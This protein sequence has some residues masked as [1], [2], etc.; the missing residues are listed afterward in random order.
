MTERT[1][2]S[3]LKSFARIA[4]L[5]D[6][7]IQ[8]R[9][10]SDHLRAIHAYI[11]QDSPQHS[12]GEYREEGAGPLYV[13]QRALETE[14]RRYLVH[15]RTD[16]IGAAVAGALKEFGDPKALRGADPQELA[17]KLTK[18]YGDLDHAHPFK[19]GNSRTLRTFTAQV[20]KE[21]GYHLDWDTTNADGKSRDKLYIARDLAVTERAFPGLNREKA[22][23][24]QDRAE[25]EAWAMFASRHQG[26]A[27]LDE[28][29]RQS[30]RPERA[31]AFET[32]SRD[33]AQAAHPELSGT[34]KRLDAIER[35]AKAEGLAGAD[36]AAVGRRAREVAGKA[37]SSGQVPADPA[38]AQEATK[39]TPEAKKAGPER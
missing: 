29:I 3:E 12:P 15:Y 8:G 28:L 11:F 17:G 38:P 9:F 31:Q 35:R 23:T 37:L 26:A 13:K 10:D 32:L 20:A 2:E 5:Q 16:G 24:T 27:R 36:L 25:S 22:M 30:L 34:Y 33:H 1:T 39:G 7:P 14:P 4:A 6:A 19:E 18:L 21:A